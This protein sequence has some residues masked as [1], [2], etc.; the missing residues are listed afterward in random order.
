[1]EDIATVADYVRYVAGLNE[2]A[3]LPV[4]PS[5]RLSELPPDRYVFQLYGRVLHGGTV[6]WLYRF[7]LWG[8]VPR[9]QSHDVRHAVGGELRRLGVS[10]PVIARIFNQVH[11]PITEYYAAPTDEEVFQTLRRLQARRFDLTDAKRTPAES[12]RLLQEARGKV[13]AFTR[14]LGGHCTLNGA[15]AIHFA[16]IGCAGKQV[17]PR[18]RGDVLQKREWALSNLNFSLEN[19]LDQEASGARQIIVDCDHELQEMDEIEI[20]MLDASQTVH[21]VVDAKSA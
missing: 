20:A 11:L 14:V 6:N 3:P 19:G 15:C 1:M 2:A 13:G 16:C 5:E 9:L 17:D 10:T 21:I 8:H 7:L 4:V 18:Y 12:I